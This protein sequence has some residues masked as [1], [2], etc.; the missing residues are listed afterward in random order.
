MVNDMNPL[1]TESEIIGLIDKAVEFR[2]SLGDEDPTF[3]TVRARVVPNMWRDYSAIENMR[4][5][6]DG[7]PEDLTVLMFELSLRQ[8]Y[9][10]NVKPLTCNTLQVNFKQGL[11][12]RDTNYGAATIDKLISVMR[13]ENEHD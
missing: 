6:Y 10:S 3:I 1:M 13:K 2:K 9:I 12:G 5:V 11:H 8:C 4:F 7:T